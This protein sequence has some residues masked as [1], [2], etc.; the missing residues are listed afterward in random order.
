MK[1]TEEAKQGKATNATPSFT[2]EIG[3][4]DDQMDGWRMDGWSDDRIP[5]G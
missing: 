3:S 4:E 1:S 2:S 5:Q